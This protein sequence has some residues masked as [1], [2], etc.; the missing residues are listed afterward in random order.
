M[1]HHIKAKITPGKFLMV[2]KQVN[3]NQTAIKSTQSFQEISLTS[4]ILKEDVN[5]FGGRTRKS[6]L[7]G[8]KMMV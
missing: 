1:H 8:V 5:L 3:R 6:K 4:N 2:E 7:F